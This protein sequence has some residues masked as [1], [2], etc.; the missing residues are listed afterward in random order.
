MLEVII[1]GG[2]GIV[3]TIVSGWVSWIFARRKYNSEVD[4][5]CIDNMQKA[6]TFYGT[7]SEDNK[8]RLAMVLDDNT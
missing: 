8:Q 1:T 5:T 6:L 3:S 2:V 7:L 4:G